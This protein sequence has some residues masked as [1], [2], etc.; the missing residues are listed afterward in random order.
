GEVTCNLFT[1]YV[2]EKAFGKALKTIFPAHVPAGEWKLRRYMASG[3]DFARWK[4]EPFTALTMYVQ[5]QDAFGWDAFTDVFAE[6]RD[7][8][9]DEKPKDDAEKRDQWMERMS[10]RVKRDLGPFFEAW[11]VPVSAEAR[12]RVSNLE[13]WMPEGLP[14]SVKA[15]QA[16]LRRLLVLLLVRPLQR[17][18]R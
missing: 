1:L 8:P 5:L 7:L 16:L 9:A 11:G 18:G 3:P 13:D 4:R 15:K 2:H 6:Y 10:R 14:P 17:D 12:E